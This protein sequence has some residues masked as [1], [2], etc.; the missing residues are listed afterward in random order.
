MIQ[1]RHTRHLDK[2]TPKNTEETRLSSAVKAE[3][4]EK[5]TLPPILI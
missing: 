3:D 4:W 1:G 5:S 2:K